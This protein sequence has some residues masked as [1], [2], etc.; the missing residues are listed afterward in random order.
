[1]ILGELKD[2]W[3]VFTG[4]SFAAVQEKTKASGA[5]PEASPPDEL[6]PLCLRLLPPARLRR[7]DHLGQK[8]ESEH[9]V[10]LSLPGKNSTELQLDRK[11][12]E[13][14]ERSLSRTGREP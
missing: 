2:R 4:S 14:E 8:H 10:F 12:T 7:A 13:E 6:S 1:M 9:T 3:F 11:Y 5:E